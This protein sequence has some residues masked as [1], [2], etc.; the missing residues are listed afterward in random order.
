MKKIITTAAMCLSLAAIMSSCKGGG[1]SEVGKWEVK[2][3]KIGG[4]TDTAMQSKMNAML[5]DE[6][7]M[8]EF[9]ADGTLKSSSKSMP[10]SEGKYTRNGDKI[11]AT[12]TKTSKVDTMT[13]VSNDGKMMTLSG[14]A[15]GQTSTMTMQKQ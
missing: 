8:M 1:A 4:V 6:H 9:N 11:I 3:M 10:G 15:D 12:D 5:A 2:S 7:M 13:V 14:T